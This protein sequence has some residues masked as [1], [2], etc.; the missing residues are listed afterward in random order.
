MSLDSVNVTLILI[1]FLYFSSDSHE[2]IDKMKKIISTTR[3]L[4][5]HQNYLQ[6][7]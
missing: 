5:L 4:I 3:L 2:F 7:K 1:N 6:L